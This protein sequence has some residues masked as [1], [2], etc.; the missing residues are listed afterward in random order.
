MEG[1]TGHE[2]EHLSRFGVLG[3]VPIPPDNPQN[4]AKIELGK[5]LFFDKRLSADGTVSCASCHNSNFGFSDALSVSVGIR[6]QKGR[7]SAP[8][9]INAAYTDAAGPLFWDGRA[10]SLEEQAL[11]PITNPI[12]MGN[13]IEN[14]VT[15]INGRTGYR[16]L[17]F[18]AFADSV[19]TAERI[20]KAIASFE[21]TIISRNA[22]FDRYLA[23]DQSALTS[24]EKRGLDIFMGEGHC[25]N[26]HNGPNL[27]D[28]KFHN[29]GVEGGVVD[30]GRFEVTQH[31]SD[32]YRFRT[33][34]LRN[35]EKTAPYFHNGSAKTLEE[36]VRFYHN[37]G[38]LSWVLSPEGRWVI[39]DTKDK[40]LP[41]HFG[42]GSVADVVAFLKTLTD[43][44]IVVV[45]PVEF[46]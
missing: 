36:A 28:N 31:P 4:N 6:G 25:I 3:E 37:T 22:R 39:N 46:P 24:Q 17:F 18:Q 9:I 43:E 20:A 7:R 5:L 30:L 8:T 1:I 13:T 14:V 41:S 32:L 10:E 26:C 27:T 33:P 45:E 29:I 2:A 16:A 23:G 38:R 44:T 15:L 21:R 35:I 34:T 12:E 42:E 19:A 11:G 40:D